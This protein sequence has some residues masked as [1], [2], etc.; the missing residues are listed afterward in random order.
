MEYTT[1]TL[2]HKL[3]SGGSA[4]GH[5]SLKC[6]A[7]GGEPRSGEPSSLEHEMKYGR[8]HCHRTHHCTF[9]HPSTIYIRARLFWNNYCL[10][11]KAFNVRTW[12]DTITFQPTTKVILFTEYLSKCFYQYTTIVCDNSTHVKQQQQQQPTTQNVNEIHKYKPN[13]LRIHSW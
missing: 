5:I 7:R 2:G 13:V 1:Y 4:D 3:I 6:S 10:R 8:R 12:I 11:A 9:T